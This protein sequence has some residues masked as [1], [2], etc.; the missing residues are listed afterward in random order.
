[1][2]AGECREERSNADILPSG[3]L[4]HVQ[5]KEKFNVNGDAF[6]EEKLDPDNGLNVLYTEEPK[7]DS[8]NSTS[9]QNFKGNNRSHN[10][11]TVVYTK[12]AIP[13]ELLKQLFKT[14]S[15]SLALCEGRNGL[16]HGKCFVSLREQKCSGD[17]SEF[18]EDIVDIF[19]NLKKSFFAICIGCLPTFLKQL[20]QSR[21]QARTNILQYC[22]H[23]NKNFQ[24]LG[25]KI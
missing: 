11:K 7:F 6:T 9:S 21:E 17:L 13:G 1:M 4:D 3:V 12:S 10:E 22:P 2:H 14:I 16:C 15:S 20:G 24:Y 19:G 18:S 5:S 23:A 25:T 8:S